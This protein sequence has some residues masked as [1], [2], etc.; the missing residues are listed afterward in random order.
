MAFSNKR[1]K[2]D[3]FW[4]IRFK[5]ICLQ[6]TQ[7]K[8]V[9][10]LEIFHDWFWFVAGTFQA[11]QNYKSCLFVAPNQISVNVEKCVTWY[12]NKISK[13]KLLSFWCSW[14]QVFIPRMKRL[15]GDINVRLGIWYWYISRLWSQFSYPK[16]FIAEYITLGHAS[17]R[18]AWSFS[19]PLFLGRLGVEVTTINAWCL[20]LEKKWQ[21]GERR[22][23]PHSKYST[24]K[25]LTWYTSDLWGKIS[26]ISLLAVT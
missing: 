22:K 7:H 12:P 26:P 3:E 16:I 6:W 21:H 18:M 5:K 19:L 8:C 25:C 11:L 15:V 14:K 20:L 17:I 4:G 24:W 1:N 10:W 13:K 9:Q 2:Q 23:M